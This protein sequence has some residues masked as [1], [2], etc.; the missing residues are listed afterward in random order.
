MAQ[1]FGYALA[2][3]GPFAIGAV[4]DWS[5]NWDVSLAVLIA[6]TVPLFVVGAEAG[7]ARTVGV[8]QPL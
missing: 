3:V 4:D 8:G 7:R 6:L 1:G 2:A 5:G